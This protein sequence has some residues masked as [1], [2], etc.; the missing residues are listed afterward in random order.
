ME[1]IGGIPLW[2]PPY[3]RVTA[4]DMNTGDH[5]WMAPVAIWRKTWPKKTPRYQSLDYLRSGARAGHLL[6][7]KTLLLVGQEGG[8][9]RESTETRLSP[10]SGRPN[11]SSTTRRPASSWAEWRFPAT[12][13]QRR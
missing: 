5:R 10:R 3:G 9:N 2:K 6:L 11:C 13:R 4:I 7:T 1:T 12:R 8:T